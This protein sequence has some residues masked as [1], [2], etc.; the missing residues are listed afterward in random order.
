MGHTQPHKIWYASA[1]RDNH[2][3]HS[4]QVFNKCIQLV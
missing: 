3:C 4:S 2:S 1:I